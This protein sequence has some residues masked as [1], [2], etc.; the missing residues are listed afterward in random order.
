MH[1][2]LEVKQY[3]VKAKIPK[4]GREGVVYSPIAVSRGIVLEQWEQCRAPEE[5]K[6]DGLVHK[7]LK[8]KQ[9]LV[10]AK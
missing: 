2:S 3:L 7:R 6:D 8:A 5:G 10:K 4:G 9:Y 1:K